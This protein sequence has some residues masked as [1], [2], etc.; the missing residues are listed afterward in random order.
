MLAQGEKAAQAHSEASLP[1]FN[2]EE[3]ESGLFVRS[4]LL[5]PAFCLSPRHQGQSRT[6]HDNN[7]Q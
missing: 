7:H 6:Q 1:I 2:G 3:K 4:L 5:D